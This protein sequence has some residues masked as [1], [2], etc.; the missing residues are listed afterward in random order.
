MRF[1]IRDDDTN[2][3]TTPED[4]EKV[5]KDIWNLCPINLSVVPFHR[6]TKSG[7]IPKK[8]WKGDDIFPIGDN[9][10]LVSFLKQKIR[11]NKISIMLHGYS[12]QDGEQY[13]EFGSHN[14]PLLHKK[15]RQGKNYL[16]ALFDTRI[17]WF[18]PPHNALSKEGL[19]AAIKNHINVVNVNSFRP[20]QRDF[21][22]NNISPFIKLKLF[23]LKHKE[24]YPFVLDFKNHKEVYHASLVP[25]TDLETLKKRFLFCYRQKG[26][27]VL[28]THYWEVHKTGFNEFWSSLQK[29][30]GIKY[31]CINNL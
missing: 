26:I 27:F 2:F 16:E 13:Y 8:H 28:A 20:D 30:K 18:V 11:E 22:F 17:S 15:I 19:R 4:L 14:Y 9:P 6:C 3:F 23:N 24:R 21:S 12:H 7:A 10:R 29:F 1:V 5:Y 25:E 31:C